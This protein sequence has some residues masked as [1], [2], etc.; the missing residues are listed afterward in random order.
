MQLITLFIH[1]GILLG[2][3]HRKISDTFGFIR[4]NSDRNECITI[5][6]K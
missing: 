3:I 1:L 6:D 2:L 4:S 5:I